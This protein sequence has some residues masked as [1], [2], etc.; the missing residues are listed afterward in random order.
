MEDYQRAE[1]ST[2][3]NVNTPMGQAALVLSLAGFSGRCGA[4]ETAES[5]LPSVK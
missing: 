4:K 3:D 2:V 5:L 1:I